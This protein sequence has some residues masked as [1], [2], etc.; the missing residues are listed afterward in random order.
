MTREEMDRKMDEHFRFEAADD[1]EGV[2]ATL[3]HDV[4]HDIVGT[5]AGPTHGRDAARAF[6]EALFTDL[7]DS[8]IEC[9]RRLYGDGFLVDES[10]WSGR[11]PGRPFGLEGRNRP[12]AF[13]MLHV[14]EFAQD[15]AIRRENVWLDLGSI[16]QQL[17]QA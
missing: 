9:V 1:V 13:R 3:S 17:P 10:R 15:G 16:Q 5:P 11:A 2:L 8:R 4:E 14:L 12:L 7:A 6:Y